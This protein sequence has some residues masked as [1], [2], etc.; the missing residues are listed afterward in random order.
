MNNQ[1]STVILNNEKNVNL[2]LLNDTNYIIVT[3]CESDDIQLNLSS[4]INS[5][6]VLFIFLKF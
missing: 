6:V 3:D 4:N 2:D 5:N 1:L